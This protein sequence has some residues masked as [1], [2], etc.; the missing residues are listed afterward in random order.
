MAQGGFGYLLE[1]ELH[2]YSG[3]QGSEASLTHFHVGR[4]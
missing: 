3:F 4:R 2:L 1:P